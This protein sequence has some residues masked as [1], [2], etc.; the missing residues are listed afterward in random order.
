M[1]YELESLRRDFWR[2]YET[3]RAAAVALNASFEAAYPP[4]KSIAWRIGM[5][6]VTYRGHVIRHGGSDSLRVE[7]RNDETGRARWITAYDVV[8]IKG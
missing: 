2:D 1:T 5:G 4:D 3:H 8:K 6:A 7:V